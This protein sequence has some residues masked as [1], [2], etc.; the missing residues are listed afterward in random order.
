MHI[1]LYIYYL[2]REW[3]GDPYEEKSA[4]TDQRK[5]F[6][7]KHNQKRTSTPQRIFSL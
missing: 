3:E 7:E 5:L 1:M 4:L 6:V 2:T